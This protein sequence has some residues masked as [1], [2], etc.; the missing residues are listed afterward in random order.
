MSDATPYDVAIAGG[1]PAGAA[2]AILCAEA[3][4]RTLVIEK[5]RFPRDKVCGDCLNPGCWPVLERL[6]VADAILATPHQ[7][8]TEVTFAAPGLS[9]L[10]L[11]LTRRD[12][13]GEIAITR[14]AFDSILLNRAAAAGAEIRENSPIVQLERQSN[15]TWRIQTGE[16]EFRARHIVAADGRNSTIAR[17]QG[18]APAARRDRVGLQTHAATSAKISGIELHLF[19]QGY[20]GTAP[21]G[22]G[23]TNFSLVATPPRLD[24]LKAAVSERFDI[25]ATES[26]RAIAPLERAPIGPL[27]NGILYVGDAA[28]VVEPFTGEGIYYALQS[29]ALA[30]ECF[31]AGKIAHYPAAHAALYRSRLW[32]NQLARWAVTHPR[33]GIALLRV[34]ALFPAALAFLVNRVNESPHMLQTAD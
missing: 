2:C 10:R 33:A 19:P 26:W 32:I 5:S 28:R 27:H 25:P 4:L 6:G 14:R 17:L 8:I 23:L 3:G 20:C 30:A 29:G 22:D 12:Q 11:Q 9:R 21:V 1:G 24:A 18:I 13:H 15:N 31:V 7:S 34:M 16:T